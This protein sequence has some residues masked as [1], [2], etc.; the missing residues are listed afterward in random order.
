VYWWLV[1]HRGDRHRHGRG[2]VLVDERSERERVE[3]ERRGEHGDGDGDEHGH[4]RDDLDV[5]DWRGELDD[6]GLLVPRL[7]RGPADGALRVRL[8]GAGLS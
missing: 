2:D 3:H 5:I 1:D 8:L 7:R 4:E 6:R